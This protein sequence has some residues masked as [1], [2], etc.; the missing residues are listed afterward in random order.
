M[1]GT[2]TKLS[3]R[4]TAPYRVVMHANALRMAS[5]GASNSRIAS[6]VRISRPTVLKCRARFLSDGLDS[7]G[8]VRV[9]RGRKPRITEHR[10]QAI[11]HATLHQTPPG[12][13]QWSSQI[14]A[15]DRTQPGLPIERGRRGTM[16][17][18]YKRDGTTTLFAALNVL[19][20]KV[21]GQCHGHHRHQ[22]STRLR[23]EA[24][25]GVKCN[26]KRWW[27]AS[28][29][30][31][32]SCTRWAYP[33]TM[34]LFCGTMVPANGFRIVSLHSPVAT[35]VPLA[36][37]GVRVEVSCVGQLAK[38][39]KRSLPSG[40]HGRTQGNADNEPRPD[41][42]LHRLHSIAGRSPV[43]I[44]VP[45]PL[46]PVAVVT[47]PSRSADKGLIASGDCVSGHGFLKEFER[48]SAQAA[49]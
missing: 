12:A 44:R 43:R 21:I 9:G 42:R 38:R 47:H 10:V 22:L 3:H 27:A 28:H 46:R 40:R 14:P 39:R 31:T 5:D 25:V 29:L 34:A 8:T 32:A 36:E 18:D 41:E 13:T 24:P 48:G 33:E 4:G 1:T 15:L 26:R 23:H 7:V 2:P 6:T 17:H 45:P 16:T 20:G 11:V 37:F 35:L 30:R 49:F 19:T